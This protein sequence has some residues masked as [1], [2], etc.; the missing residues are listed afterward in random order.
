M[1]ILN[2]RKPV[3][4]REGDTRSAQPKVLRAAEVILVSDK[5]FSGPTIPVPIESST[6]SQTSGLKFV[7]MKR[8]VPFVALVVVTIQ[9]VAF[10]QA[11]PQQLEKIWFWFGDC[12]EPSP[13][14]VQVLLEGK[15]IYQSHFR[16]CQMNRTAANTEREQK[17]RTS[18]H[19]SGGH[20]FQGTHHTRETETIQ[21]TIWQAGADTDD[22][23]LG[24]SLLTHDQVSLNTI[25]IVKPGKTT[26]SKL[27][28]GLVLKTYPIKSATEAR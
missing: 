27:D 5:R 19:F 18:F 8:I 26:E 7:L 9:P 12:P 17:V 16:A 21:G 20:T 25:H 22:I 4:R 14:R 28:P 11:S 1:P 13:M 15:T 10:R 24:V 2:H 6:L 23:L 3:W